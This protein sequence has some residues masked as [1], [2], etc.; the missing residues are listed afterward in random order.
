MA[1]STLAQ[2]IF[3]VLVGIG[4][5]AWALFGQYLPGIIGRPAAVAIAVVLFA[6]LLAC[7][8][9]L[10]PNF[11]IGPPRSDLAAPK[12]VRYSIAGGLLISCSLFM[13]LVGKGLVMAHTQLQAAT[14]DKFDFTLVA[15]GLVLVLYVLRKSGV[16]RF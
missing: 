8:A 7:F 10:R 16:I 4:L 9:I 15:I 13:M 3:G 11:R 14:I 12:I 2:R 1:I 6:A 5:A